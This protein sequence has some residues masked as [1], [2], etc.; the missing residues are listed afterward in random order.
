MLAEFDASSACRGIWNHHMQN[1]DFRPHAQAL[2]LF[3]LIGVS[4]FLHASDVPVPFVDAGLGPCTVDF[5]V[6]GRKYQP[7]YNAQIQVQ[8][9]YGLWGLKRMNLQV[10]TNG[11]GKGRFTGLPAKLRKPPL[12]FVIRYGKAEQHWYWTGLDCHQRF[13]VVLNTD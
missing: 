5:V 12:D 10:G 11:D 4:G 7:L 8:F 1:H 6:E 2:L 9:E 13:V 3:L